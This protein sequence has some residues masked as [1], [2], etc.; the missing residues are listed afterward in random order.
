MPAI[1]NRK[2]TRELLELKLTEEEQSKFDASCE[3]LEKTIR[4]VIDPIL[5]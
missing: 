2:G 4:E 1:I 3:T 5:E